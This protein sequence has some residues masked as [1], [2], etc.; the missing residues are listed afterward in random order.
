MLLTTVKKIA[1]DVSSTQS[2]Q[3]KKKVKN[4]SDYVPEVTVSELG[5]IYICRNFLEDTCP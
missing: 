2:Y 1:A 4:Y 5:K 3:K